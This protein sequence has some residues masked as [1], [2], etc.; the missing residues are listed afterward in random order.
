MGSNPTVSANVPG[1]YTDD[2]TG[3]SGDATGDFIGRLLDLTTPSGA[4]LPEGISKEEAILMIARW[5]GQQARMPCVERIFV[6]LASLSS[7]MSW[8]SPEAPAPA[9]WQKIGTIALKNGVN[10]KTVRRAIRLLAEHGLVELRV[11]N[12]FYLG[13]TVDGFH[14]ISFEPALVRFGQII[15]EVRAATASRDH[16]RQRIRK[17]RRELSMLK[18]SLKTHLGSAAED[19][20]IGSVIDEL[21]LLQLEAKRIAALKCGTERSR[22][23]LDELESDTAAAAEAAER[24]LGGDRPVKSGDESIEPSSAPS[25][26]PVE[27]SV[28]NPVENSES[29]TADSIWT[30]KMSHAA[31]R[32]SV[33]ILQK[34]EC[35]NNQDCRG[36]VAEE[37]PFRQ[38]PKPEESPGAVERAGEDSGADAQST[39]SAVPAGGINPTPE[40]I[41]AFE[42][43]LQ[44]L[45]AAGSRRREQQQEPDAGDRD[46]I[47]PP[48][49]AR[50][51]DRKCSKE[52]GKQ[53]QK[54][55]EQ[56]QDIMTDEFAEAVSEAGDWGYAGVSRFS[57][58]ARLVCGRLGVSRHAWAEA[59]EQMGGRAILVL[60][61]IDRNRFHPDRPVHSPGGALRAITRRQK[62]GICDIDR[63][64]AAIRWRSKNGLQP[65][66]KKETLH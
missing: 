12:N 46:A 10:R 53:P 49:V 59:V 44:D 11:G 18:R 32:K 31:D 34:R 22:S 4:A 9:C 56:I 14:G 60:A 27:N 63:S 38:D 25:S 48:E 13:Q 20:Q 35:N 7:D 43:L 8:T 15:A 36:E 55:L 30:E 52:R 57:V 51:A 23:R 58:A 29:A 33:P 28:E 65:R 39:G 47:A 66:G 16:E 24:V 41:E 1:C 37:D 45:A 17:L 19:E 62:A 6:S 2:N 3:E 64:V 5:I 21:G 61:V 26:R 54:I 40:D 42:T 50:N